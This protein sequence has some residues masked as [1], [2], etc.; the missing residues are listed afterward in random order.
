MIVH[1]PSTATS[2]Y[3]TCHSLTLQARDGMKQGMKPAIRKAFQN[4]H[5]YPN[6]LDPYEQQLDP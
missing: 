5:L 2:D 3:L 4:D 6:E 1:P